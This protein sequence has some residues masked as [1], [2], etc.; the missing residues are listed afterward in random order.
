MT[1]IVA[2]IILLSAM[3]STT[4]RKI[5]RAAVSFAIADNGRAARGIPRGRARG[6][7]PTACR[8][9]WPGWSS[10]WQACRGPSPRP[11]RPW[12]ADRSPG[13]LVIDRDRCHVPACRPC[14][15]SSPGWSSTGQRVAGLPRGRAARGA[16]RRRASWSSTWQ[17]VARSGPRAAVPPIVAGLVIDLA[18]VSRAF[19]A[20]VP[21]VVPIVAGQAG[22]R[23]GAFPRAAR[24]ADRRRAWSSTWQ[25][26]EG[27]PRGRAARAVDRRRVDFPR[28]ACHAEAFPSLSSCFGAMTMRTFKFCV[29]LLLALC[30]VRVSPADEF[31]FPERQPLARHEKKFYNNTPCRRLAF[32]PPESFAREWGCDNPKCCAP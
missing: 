15:R 6:E 1:A 24:A 5:F 12:S 28:A 23:P 19:P 4:P 27:L 2:S 17:R 8:R 22:H 10:T 18:S 26:V 25:R 29:G 20:A 21:P 9:S 14:R 13:K 7:F 16:D 30:A 31:L 3:R 32:Q 11:C